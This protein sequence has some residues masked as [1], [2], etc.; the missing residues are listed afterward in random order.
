MRAHRHT[1]ASFQRVSVDPKNRGCLEAGTDRSTTLFSIEDVPVS[2]IAGVPG[3]S[4][5]GL[6]GDL[7]A[8][9]GRRRPS[10]SA[11]VS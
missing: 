5:S 11:S 2:P 7:A 4:F 3:V 9:S 6:W 10:E 1:V 8:A